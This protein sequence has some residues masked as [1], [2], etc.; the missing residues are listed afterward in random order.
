MECKFDG[1]GKP[2][3]GAGYC[4]GHYQQYNKGGIESLKPLRE[5]LK[6]D[7]TAKCGVDGC[8]NLVEKKHLCGMHYQRR[9]KHGDPLIVGKA[10]SRLQPTMD[11]LLRR[12]TPGKPEDCWEWQG[13]TNAKGYG[14]ITATEINEQLAHRVAY[15]L[16][17][18]DI[19]EGLCVLHKCDN[20]KCCNPSHFFLGDNADNTRDM[21]N[22]RRQRHKLS[23]DDVREIRDRN[24]SLKFLCEKF[25]ITNSMISLVRRKKVYTYVI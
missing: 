13:S 4:T 23:E 22:K 17:V 3:R 9:K 14:F 8:S 12:L 2:A 15:R 18:G 5:R 6:I 25:S 21:V 16:W 11:K 19:P 1:C 10:P 7:R 20:R 24:N